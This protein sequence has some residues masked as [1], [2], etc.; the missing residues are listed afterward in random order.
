MTNPRRP[1]VGRAPMLASIAVALALATG[2]CSGDGSDKS[3]PTEPS[4]SGPT[5]APP[6]QTS[7]R[8]GT[9]TGHLAG[10][11]RKPLKNG[12]TVAVDR[13]FD[14]AFVAGHYPRGDFHDAFAGFTAGARNEAVRDRRLMSNADIGRR[15]DAVDANRRRLH[16]DVLAVHGKP[17]GVT[18]RFAL[19]FTTSGRVHK[20]FRV[21]GSLF[22]THTHRH[23]RVFGYDVTKG[24]IR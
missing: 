22:L 15:I 11:Q 16:I 18:A 24:G 21:Q 3:G 1:V 9:I 8:L 17:V 19:V 14:H 23:W 7:A 20:R 6:V 10:K 2:A 5:S 4:S 12:V 13:W